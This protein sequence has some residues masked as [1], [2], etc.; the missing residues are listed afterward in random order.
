MSVLT[1]AFLVSLVTSA[2]TAVVVYVL[3]ARFDPRFAPAPQDAVLGAPTGMV[4]GPPSASLPV[5]AAALADAPLGPS[6]PPAAAP[7]VPAAAPAAATEVPRL[8]GQPV[9][10]AKKILLER[11]LLVVLAEARN[12]DAVPAEH[13][14]SQTPLAGSIVV[15]G[16]EVSV[17]VSR[18]PLPVEVPDVT[19]LGVERATDMLGEA[20]LSLGSVQRRNAE[21]PAGEIVEMRP[22][23][24]ERVARGTRVAIVVSDGPR[25]VV[26]PKVTRRGIASARRELEAAG[27]VPGRIV[28]TYDLDFEPGV[29]VRQEPKGGDQ[30]PTGSEVRLWGSEPE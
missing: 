12:D 30:A 13:V 11:R 18:G 21:A 1:K 3:M 9:E 22:L 6:G 15:P 29:V 20:G 8:V 23:A 2:A 25:M 14:I 7:G 27:F 28:W 26:V 5:G 16:T 10:E 19:G 4:V 24:G 17:I